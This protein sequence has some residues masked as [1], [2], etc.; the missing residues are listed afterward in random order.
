MQ[1]LSLDQEDPLEKEMATHYSILAREIL[2]TEEPGRVQ[3]TVAKELD[4]TEWLNNNSKVSLNIM[5]IIVHHS[6][7]VLCFCIIQ[8]LLKNEENIMLEWRILK[9]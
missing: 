3:S 6:N 9:Y 4:R 1:F 7:T 5:R 8:L 2:W